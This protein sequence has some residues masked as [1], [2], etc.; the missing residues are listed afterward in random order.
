M[1]YEDLLVN[2]LSVYYYVPKAE[3]VWDDEF[4]SNSFNFIS[5]F[6]SNPPLTWT[7]TTTGSKNHGTYVGGAIDRGFSSFTNT[8]VTEY[9]MTHHKSRS[10]SCFFPPFLQ[11][12]LACS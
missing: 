4:L 6:P 11:R 10:K 12:H 2:F 3:V 5:H 7:A 8:L 1:A 9:A